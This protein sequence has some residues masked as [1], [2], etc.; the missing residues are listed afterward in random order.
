ML[1]ALF[2]R[3][4]S[5]PL[6]ALLLT[7]LLAACGSSSD[8][9]ATSQ[10]SQATVE[11]STVNVPDP[12]RYQNQ[13]LQVLDVSEQQL[14]GSATLVV[15]FSIPL[16]EKQTFADHARVTLKG[17]REVQFK[18]AWE[19]SPD[20]TELRLRH[21]PPKATLQ[22]QVDK[23]LTS[24]TGGQ[25]GQDYSI[26]LETSD[27]TPMVGFASRGSLLPIELADGLPVHSLN[28]NEVDVDFYR[29]HERNLHRFIRWHD[30]S[31][32]LSPWDN[33]ELQ[34]RASL[35]YSGRFDLNSK[36]N[37]QQRT[38]L[39]IRE[40]E[41]LQEPGI[42]FAVMRQAGDHGYYQPAT[43]FSQSDIGLSVHS[44]AKGRYEI[45][46]LGLSNGRPLA[47][48]EISLYS[49]KDERTAQARTDKNGHASLQ[50]DTSL[51]VARLGSQTSFLRL[52]G[53]ALNLSEFEHIQ[54][55]KQ[56]A[57]QLFAFSPRDLY[58]PG[59]TLQFNALLRDRDG[60]MLDGGDNDQRPLEVEISTPE[61][62]PYD[63]FVWTPQHPGFYQH[64]FTLSDSAPTGR[65]Q[66]LIRSG[67]LLETLHEL[68]VE[69]FMPERMA[70]ELTGS[71]HPLKPADPVQVDIKGRFLYGAPAA[72]SQ[73][74]GQLFV[75]PLREAVPALPGYVFGSITEKLP[76]EN[77]DFREQ[78][79]NEQGEAQ[80]QHNSQW[81]SVRS[82][83]ELIARV[84]LME[85]GGRP[86]TRRLLQPVWPASQLPG[87]LPRFDKG[88]VSENSLAAFQVVLANAAGEQL[89]SNNL[90]VRLV[91]ERRDYY[92]SYSPSGG[93]TST[94]NE[95]TY[96]VQQHSL[97]VVPGQPAEVEFPVQRGAYRIEVEDP[98]T[99]LVSSERFWAGYR[100]QDS[101]QD[102]GG[103]RPDQVRL[104]LDK[105]AY[106]NGDTAVVR[107]EAPHAG[108][109]YLMLESSEGL[110]WWQTIEVPDTGLDVQVPVGDYNGHD[111]YLSALVIRPGQRNAEQTA[112]RAVGLLHLP[113]NREQRRLQVT[114]DTPQKMRPEQPLPIRVQVLDASG[115][116]VK[117]AH[118]LV[119]AVDSGVLNIT[120]FKTPDPWQAFFGRKAYA[121]DQYDL[122]SQLIDASNAIAA[123]LRFGGDAALEQGGGRPKAHVRIV[124]WQSEV[125]ET[126]AQGW[127]SVDMPMPDFNGEVRVMAQAWTAETF[128]HQEAP[129]T[130]AAPLVAEMSLPRFLANGDQS[131]LALDL[132]NLSGQPQQLQLNLGNDSL[133]QLHQL[134][135]EQ[136][137][138]TPGQRLVLPLEVSAM[139]TGTAELSLQISGIQ[140]DGETLPAMQRNWKLDVRSPWP[141]QSR[142]LTHMLQPD[143]RWS[144]PTDWLDGLLPG[145]LNGRLTLSSQPVTAIETFVTNLYHYPYGCAEQTSSRLLPLLYLNAGQLSAMTGKPT[146]NEEREKLLQAVLQHILAKQ[147]HD[148]SIGMWS[149]DSEEDYWDTV[150]VTD[151]LQRARKQGLHVPPAAYQQL[152]DRL[153]RYVREGR[154]ISASGSENMA[155]TRFAVQA[156]AALVLARED[157]VALGTL[158]SLYGKAADARTPLPLMHLA[159]A[160]Q[161]AGDGQRARELMKQAPLLTRKQYFWVGDYGSRL[162][163]QGWQILLLQ[164]SGLLDDDTRSRLLSQLIDTTH[165]KRW[166]STQENAALFMALH[167]TGLLD[168]DAWQASLDLNGH[169]RSLSPEQPS[170]SL[171]NKA[172]NSPPTLHNSSDI[173]L[174]QVLA[175][176]GETPEYQ[177]LPDKVLNISREY[178]NLDGTP[179]QLDVPSG[180]LLLVHLTIS[181]EENVQDALVVDMLPAGFEL[182][183]QNLETSS[184]MLDEIEQFKKL[185]KLMQNADISMQ[186]W[187]DDRYAAAVSVHPY[188][189]THL[190]YLVR[191]VTPGEYLLPPVQVQSMYR[192]DWQAEY[193]KH[194]EQQVIIR[195]R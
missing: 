41:P 56:Q 190:L 163:E 71:E 144:M 121:H 172:L 57:I 116:P 25:L 70:L 138:L 43:L 80:L 86:V 192:P 47:D 160:L 27:L 1:S 35:V 69:D 89:A 115:Q 194:N 50:G 162:T 74:Q 177:P 84:S 143:E 2:S 130:V 145:S 193:L 135:P 20:Q 124:S 113:L 168:G 158:R 16:Q 18:Q 66:I 23:E 187:M 173:P 12:D 120:E 110:H 179:A 19:L 174:F 157:K 46:A 181:A 72:G 22:V 34:K 133:V 11:S 155:H 32:S 38:L 5:H 45:F 4:T 90:Q 85:S 83:L 21:L 123:R 152:L 65:W 148:G 100:W 99:G 67:D 26:S 105:P 55:E 164:E 62:K 170:V 189:P 78:I 111:L 102:G 122:Y 154:L 94:Y 14:E 33:D 140:A 44:P 136:I 109:G 82:P 186:A 126:D 139:A 79:T 150:Y 98:A 106:H 13:Q 112:K 169:H 30:G 60:R 48:V 40:L 127:A 87:I 81:D 108:S 61:G 92:W 175:V 125:L 114:L 118:A 180:T 159:V 73:V 75:R 141:A 171:G 36:D 76:G 107:V 96:T 184:V 37:I 39:P 146:S 77:L 129:V 185:A 134:P 142:R 3:V 101:S 91:R 151:V 137:E 131:R 7:A 182:E 166:Y 63:S 49:H 8:E 188:R 176:R 10:T 132:H 31:N 119:S 128:A 103:I 29:V 53:S 165:S 24:I 183:N 42:Y 156:Y 59:E 58:R 15:T 88:Q 161:Q 149:P 17:T 104:Q 147:R 64:S 153:Q 167:S 28:V 195:G 52:Q 51:I 97:K 9:P 6:P 178:Y 54:G 117:N 93:W 68:Q 95:K 191:A